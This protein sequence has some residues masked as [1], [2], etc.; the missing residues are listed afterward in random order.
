MEE[1]LQMA[2]GDDDIESMSSLS[3]L[4]IFLFLEDVKLLS[5]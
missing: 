4:L 2:L 5:L 1:E 3:E